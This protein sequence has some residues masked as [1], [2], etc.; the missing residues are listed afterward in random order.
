MSLDNDE[1]DRVL[2]EEH[3]GP[4]DLDSALVTI[5]LSDVVEHT[6]LVVEANASLAAVIEAMQRDDR[7]TVL[8]VKARKLVGIFT[9]RNVLMKAAGLPIDVTQAR[10]AP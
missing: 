10:S 6:P 4:G 3:P 1:T 7:G 5:T 8:V 2:E 9:G